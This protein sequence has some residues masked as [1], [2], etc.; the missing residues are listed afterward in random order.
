MNPSVIFTLD[1]INNAGFGLFPS[2][3]WKILSINGIQPEFSYK[4]CLNKLNR[5]SLKIKKYIFFEDLSIQ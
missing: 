1:E 3:D 5:K 2:V 4:N